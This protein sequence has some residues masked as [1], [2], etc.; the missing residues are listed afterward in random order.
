MILLLLRGLISRNA[1]R[2]KSSIKIRKKIR[3]KSKIK[4][5]NLTS[6]SRPPSN[7]GH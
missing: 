7:S 5:R 3:S 6:R 4:I 1:R 2:I